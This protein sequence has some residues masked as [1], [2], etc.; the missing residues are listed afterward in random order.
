MW[1]R[2]GGAFEESVEA[3]RAAACRDL[4]GT[5][6]CVAPGRIELVCQLFTHRSKTQDGKGPR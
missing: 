1:P 6:W 3:E 5:N 2:R 4:S